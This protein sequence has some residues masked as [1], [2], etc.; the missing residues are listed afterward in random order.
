M[1]T[2]AFITYGDNNRTQMI[3]TAGPGHLEDRTISSACNPYLSFAAYVAAGLDGIKRELLPGEPN[4]ENMYEKTVEDLKARSIGVL[5]QSLEEALNCLEEDDIVL[6]GLGPLAKDFVELKRL[7][8]LEYHRLVS[9]W[10]VDRYLTF[11]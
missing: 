7:E 11:F 10:E 3:R 2:P 6:S 8:W 1:W 5:P 4:K 9:Q